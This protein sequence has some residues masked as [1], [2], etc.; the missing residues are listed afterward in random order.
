V[1]TRWLQHQE[2]A[3][4]FDKSYGKSCT[5]LH[6]ALQSADTCK[7]TQTIGLTFTTPRSLV[8]T[9]IGGG[10]RFMNLYWFKNTNQ[11]WMQT[12]HWCLYAFLICNRASCLTHG[13][14]RHHHQHVSSWVMYL[15]M[16][17]AIT[18]LPKQPFT[19]FIFHSAFLLTGH[20][21]L[22]HDHCSLICNALMMITG[23]IE[24]FAMS[25]ISF[26]LAVIF[27]TRLFNTSAFRVPNNTFWPQNFR[28][29]LWLFFG[30]FP[31]K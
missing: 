12:S 9:T 10:C 24:T 30:R 26:S 14:T 5:E 18:S 17:R 19:F 21:N 3:T 13:V 4:Q 6:Q 8:V 25:L 23:V 22:Q 2:N 15:R 16:L 7:P 1:L 20:K 29:A 27:N 31:S 11:S 28:L